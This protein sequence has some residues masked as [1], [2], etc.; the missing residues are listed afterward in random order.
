MVEKRTL[1]EVA[2]I[3]AFIVSL[4]VNITNED[5]ADNIYAC[6][7]ESVPDYYC[8]KLSKVNDDGIQ[9]NCY[10]DTEATR[11]YKVCSTGWEKISLYE[12]LG[13][14]APIIRQQQSSAGDWI[15]PTPETAECYPVEG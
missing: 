14:P 12:A 3:L 10:Y 15:C 13:E 9:R 2:L 4:G 6:G 5:M 8:H 1:A 7:V 11:R